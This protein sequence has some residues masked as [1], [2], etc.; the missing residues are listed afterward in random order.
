MQKTRFES[1]MNGIPIKLIKVIQVM[2]VK[3]PET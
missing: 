2:N 1:V 3:I